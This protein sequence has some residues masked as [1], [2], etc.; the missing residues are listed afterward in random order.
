MNARDDR[1][2]LPSA[3]SMDRCYHCPGSPAAER[4]LTA[5]T[6]ES[7]TA[8]GTAIHE[9][10]ETGDDEDLGLSQAEIKDRLVGMEKRAID[11]WKMDIFNG[12]I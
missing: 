4:G 12:V 5:L 9:A 1:G 11:Q 3:S 6:I 2:E 8:D 10:I 7:V